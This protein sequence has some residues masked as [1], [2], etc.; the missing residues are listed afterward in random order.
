MKNNFNNLDQPI[1]EF[2]PVIFGLND[3]YRKR[4]ISFLTILLSAFKF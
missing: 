2:E 3:Y 1:I 4:K